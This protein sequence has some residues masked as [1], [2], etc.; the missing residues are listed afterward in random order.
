VRN[1]RIGAATLHRHFWYSDPAL[2]EYSSD[3]QRIANLSKDFR[4]VSPEASAPCKCCNGSRVIL[5]V[6]QVDDGVALD[7]SSRLHHSR[8]TE[9]HSQISLKRQAAYG[10]ML[11]AIAKRVDRR[12]REPGTCGRRGGRTDRH[13]GDE[14]P[15]HS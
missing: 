14:N 7:V 12:D 1:N 2:S 3:E 10:W 13:S 5:E 8:S 11:I 4:R 6:G 9:R 15:R